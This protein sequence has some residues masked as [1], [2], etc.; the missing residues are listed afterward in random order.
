MLWQENCIF[1]N[2][3]A[4]DIVEQEIRPKYLRFYSYKK[5]QTIAS[6]G[7]ICTQIGIVRQ[8]AVEVQTIYPS[9]KVL[10]HVRLTEGDVFGEALVFNP[11]N[12]YP[13]TIIAVEACEI[14]YIRKDHLLEIFHNYPAALNNYLTLLSNRLMTLN[15]KIRNLSLDTLDKRIANYL[16][17]RYK[18]SG[19]KMF[20]TG[21]SRKAMAEMMGVQRP[22]LSRSLSQLKEDGA[23]DFSGD[24]FKIIDVTKLEKILA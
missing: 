12:H 24:A 17:Q 18:K 9:G 22:S 23:I 14:G 20:T 15:K 4:Q 5:G 13:V 3:F 21:L 16:L 7:E 19:S 8:G 6:E 10:T 2:N 1:F 11:N